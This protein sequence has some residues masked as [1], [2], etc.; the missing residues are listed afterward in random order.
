MR[1][2]RRTKKNI[3]ENRTIKHDLIVKSM[4][5]ILQSERQQHQT[6]VSELQHMLDEERQQIN[7]FLKD[8]KQILDD[9]ESNDSNT[10]LNS[11][12]VIQNRKISLFEHNN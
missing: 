2:N 5:S 10:S 6:I 12:H 8:M 11:I 4:I 7:I 1:S 3:P 9:M